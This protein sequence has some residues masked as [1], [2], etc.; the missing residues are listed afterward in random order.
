M[1][2]VL[3][4]S[5]VKQ[6]TWSKVLDGK[7]ISELQL[8]HCILLSL[9]KL[10]IKKDQKIEGRE[11]ER[12]QWTFYYV[13]IQEDLFK[14]GEEYHTNDTIHFAKQYLSQW[15]NCY[16]GS[17][18]QCVSV[19]DRQSVKQYWNNTNIVPDSGAIS[20]MVHLHFTIGELEF[21]L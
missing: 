4:P 8:L 7:R 13:I 11:L 16:I 9:R 2:R 17:N 1:L 21:Q 15:R 14:I 19:S 5:Q 12:D 18:S 6:A 3:G 20:N 10:K